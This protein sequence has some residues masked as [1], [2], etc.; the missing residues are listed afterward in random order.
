MKTAWGKPAYCRFFWEQKIYSQGIYIQHHLCRSQ[1]LKEHELLQTPSKIKTDTETQLHLPSVSMR[2]GGETGGGQADWANSAQPRREMSSTELIHPTPGVVKANTGILPQLS[3]FKHPS[4]WNKVTVRSKL[5]FKQVQHS[6][7]FT[8]RRIS[9]LEILPN[10]PVIMD[11]ED[12]A[13]NY[14]FKKINKHLN[15]VHD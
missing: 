11:V 14:A 8:C 2:K 3:K 5:Q 10:K 15:S 6:S 1:R 4:F 13:F 7:Y 9:L 12:Y